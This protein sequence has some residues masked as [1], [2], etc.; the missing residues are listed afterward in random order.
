MF[1]FL[2][3]VPKLLLETVDPF[4]GLS[5]LKQYEPSQPCKWSY[6]IYCLCSVD[7]IMHI[8]V[9][10]QAKFHQYFAYQTLFQIQLWFCT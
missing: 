1:H 8:L 3:S 10:I 9:F 2:E 5:P 6:K 7:Q 4:K